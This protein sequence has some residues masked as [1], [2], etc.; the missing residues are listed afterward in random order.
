MLNQ[1]FYLVTEALVYLALNNAEAVSGKKLYAALKISGR[2]L[3]PELQACVNAGILRSVRGPKGGYVLA[4]EKRNINLKDV[5]DL[6][7]D[8]SEDSARIF[9]KRILQPI[10]SEAEQ[11]YFAKFEAT[12]LH[13]LWESSREKHLQSAKKQNPDFTI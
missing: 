8:E 7:S 1:K 9:Y 10:I 12:T 5:F 2:S 4:K 3:E 13:E 6:I 11:E